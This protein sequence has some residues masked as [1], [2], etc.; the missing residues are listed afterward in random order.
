LLGLVG[1][2]GEFAVTN[3]LGERASVRKRLEIMVGL[4]L[5]NVL[6]LELGLLIG[7][8]S[9]VAIGLALGL[10]FGLLC[11]VFPGV[12]FGTSIFMVNG[13]LRGR[14]ASRGVPKNSDVGF[15]REGVTGVGKD[16]EKN[17]RRAADCLCPKRETNLEQTGQVCH[18]L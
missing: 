17:T 1:D 8:I 3:G 9:G 11:E 18:R 10:V 7:V 15:E 4:M 5:A 16:R 6:G 14:R 2:F 12:S 13:R